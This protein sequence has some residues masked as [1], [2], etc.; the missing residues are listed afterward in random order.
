MSNHLNVSQDE[1]I[2]YVEV[3]ERIGGDKCFLGELLKIYFEE[4]NEKRPLLQAAIEQGDF[5]QIQE[6]GHSLK[7]ASANLSLTLLKKASFSLE[8]AGREKKI[9]QAQNAFRTLEFEFQRLKDHLRDS[10]LKMQRT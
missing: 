7:G 3:L 1:P 5:T 9:A 6:L 4:F 8:V 10:P 2:D